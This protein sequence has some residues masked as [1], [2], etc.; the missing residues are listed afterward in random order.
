V[1]SI[2]IP[3][4]NYNTF[5]L[6]K[7][8]HKQLI[9]SK[10][11]F[12]IICLDDASDQKYKQENLKI[13]ALEFSTFSIL[14]KNIGRSKIRNKLVALAK[15][16]YLLFLDAD[17][18]P[19]N[20]NFIETYLDSISY[21]NKVIYGGISYRDKKPENAKLL[22]WT[23]GKSR[24][25]VSISKRKSN[26][27]KHFLSANFLIHKSL[28]SS[29]G[30]NETL[31]T[32]GHE[33]S[34]FAIDLKK[35]AIEISPIE[36]TVFH[37]GIESNSIFLEKIK[38]SVKNAFYLYTHQFIDKK[39]IHLV[40]KYILLKTLRIDGFMAF[41]FRKIHKKWENNLFSKNPSLLVLDFYK[42]GYL[43]TI[44]NAS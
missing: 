37:L 40:D 38:A 23:Y 41:I 35:S 16:N 33:D 9:H 31:T 15:Y 28:F 20:S 26:P 17:V 5:P 13:N 2:L 21:K 27:Y 22:R 7:E 1:I 30:F 29:H 11:V 39:D 14:D 24:E 8:I 36:N 32:Y 42:L 43:C 3:T 10:K 6:V 19:K 25:E 18:I 12:E 4:Y 44:A 34:L